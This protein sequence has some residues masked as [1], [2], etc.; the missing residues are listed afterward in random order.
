MRSHAWGKVPSL[1]D[2][3]TAGCL[4]ANADKTGHRIAAIH[5]SR[6]N[7]MFLSTTYDETRIAVSD[8]GGNI[9]RTDDA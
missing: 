1:G 9:Y 3:G 6:C 8:A 2:G 7:S 5:V 4:A